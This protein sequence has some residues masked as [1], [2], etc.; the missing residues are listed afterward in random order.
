MPVKKSERPDGSIRVQTYFTK[1]TRM[2]Q[3]QVAATDV[4]LIMSRYLKSG[5]S[6]RNLPDPVG[7][8]A[9][10][11]SVSDLQHSLNTVLDAQRAFDAL[12]SNLRARFQNDPVQLVSFLEDPSNKPEAITLG[13]IPKPTPT[14]IPNELSNDPTP[15]STP[16]PS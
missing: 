4:N 10:L 7:M 6:L 3:S 14:P 2:Q 5:G 13:L 8:Y 1:P 12:P 15:T 11:T 16:K 9:D